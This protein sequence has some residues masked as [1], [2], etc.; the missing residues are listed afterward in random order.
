MAPDFMCR[1][2]ALRD[3]GGFISFP[4][5][6]YSDDA[7]WFSLAKRGGVA[8][9]S[10]IL[11][12]FRDSGLNITSVPRGLAEKKL[13]SLPQFS[14]WFK[15]YIS[16]VHPKDQL[17]E[18]FYNIISNRYNEPI[19]ATVPLLVNNESLGTIL[20]LYFHYRKTNIG[21]AHR[22]R[23]VF[24]YRLSLFVMGIL[25]KIFKICTFGVFSRRKDNP[26]VRKIL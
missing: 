26:E 21:I 24:L 1:T 18:T 23:D 8:W 2:S 5:A 17:Q 3:I 9:S 25:L 4:L 12:Y 22:I 16:E 7:T 19:L 10:D 6:W 11:F 14:D 13:L 20:S 15:I